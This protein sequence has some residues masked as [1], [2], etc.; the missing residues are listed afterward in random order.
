[1]PLIHW[2]RSLSVGVADFDKQHQ[3][4]IKLINDLNDAMMQ[5]KG[6]S[7]IGPIISELHKY[8]ISHFSAE[9]A[10]LERIGYPNIAK[11]KSE[12][13]RFISDIAKFERDLIEGGVGLSVQVINFLSD[14]LRRHIQG[15]DAQ[16]KSYCNAKGIV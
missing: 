15:D 5:G 14:W 3:V 1:M 11:Q 4:L 8:T 10:V 7:L 6:S 16:Y 9:E 13:K 2:D 12:H